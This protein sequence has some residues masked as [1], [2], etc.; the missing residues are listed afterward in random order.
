MIIVGGK[1]K[2]AV[3]NRIGNNGKPIRIGTIG[4]GDTKIIG[5]GGSGQIAS[6]KIP[7]I[8]QMI[9]DSAICEGNRVASAYRIRKCKTRIR[10]LPENG[11]C[12]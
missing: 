9:P 2:Y 5:Y 1:P 4:K 11:R 8:D 3:R 7:M 12:H 10:A 6:A